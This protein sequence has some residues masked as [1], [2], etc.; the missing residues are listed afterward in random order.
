M[1]EFTGERVIPGLV[2]DDLF[3]EHLSRYKFAARLVPPGASVLDVGCGTGYGSAE[4]SSVTGADV[5]A[6]AV[7]YARKHYSR[8]GVQFIEASGD[9]LPLDQQFDLIT[10]FEVIEHLA[11]WRGLLRE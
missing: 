7:E 9:A 6:E 1:A 8:P 3:N 4:F 5:S 10:A 11:D 2:E